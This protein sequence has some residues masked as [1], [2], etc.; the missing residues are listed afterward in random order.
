MRAAALHRSA[1][2]MSGPDEGRLPWVDT[3]KGACIV[4]VVMMHATLG[5]GEAMSGEGFMHWIVAFARPFRMPDFF[6]VSGLFLS[7]VIDRDWR[8]YGDK[9]V[10]HFLYFYLLWLVIQSAFKFGQVSGGTAAGFVEHLAR[11]LIE[12]YSTC[13]SSTCSRRSRS[14]RS[15]C[16]AS[17]ARPC[18]PVPPRCRSPRSRRTGRSSTSFAV[19]SSTSSPAT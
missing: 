4:L 8:S 2:P 16:A 5:V 19:G 9:R 13:G 3:A 10:V 7:R 1:A 18:S 11:A 15:C 17:L 14:S 6:L 12:P